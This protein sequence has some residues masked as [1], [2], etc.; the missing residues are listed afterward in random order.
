MNKRTHQKLRQERAHLFTMMTT[1][2]TTT[3][4]TTLASVLP[5][6]ATRMLGVYLAVEVRRIEAVMDNLVRRW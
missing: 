1:T 5:L 2:T 4:T 6:V 3:T